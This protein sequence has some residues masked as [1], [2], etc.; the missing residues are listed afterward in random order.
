MRGKLTLLLLTAAACSYD[1]DPLDPRLGE[2]ASGGDATG[3]VADGGTDGGAAGAAGEGG[4]A[5]STGEGGRAGTAGGAGAAGAAGAAAGNAGQAGTA[6]SAGQPAGGEGGGVV[7]AGAGGAPTGGVGGWAGAPGGEAG[8]AGTAGAAAA[9]GSCTDCGTE[10][11]DLNTSTDH[12]GACDRPCNTLRVETL[13]CTDGVCDSTCE[14]GTANCSRP[15]APAADNGCETSVSTSVINCG[16]CGR[17][18]DSTNIDTIRCR[19]GLCDGTCVAGWA[20]CNQP[21]APELDDGCETRTAAHPDCSGCA[22]YEVCRDGVCS[23]ACDATGLNAL[24]VVGADSPLSAADQVAYDWLLSELGFGVTVVLDVDAPTA[25]VDA[26]ALVVIS[27]T[28]FGDTPLGNAF[29]G[30]N[31]PVVTWERMLF[32]EFGLTGP[33]LDTHYGLEAGQTELTLVDP[34]HPAA[35]GLEGTVTVFT[36]AADATW[37]VPAVSA[38]TIATSVNDSSHA[39]LFAIETGDGLYDGTPAPAR[40]MGLFLYDTGPS[41]ATDDAARLVLASFCWAAGL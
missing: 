23:A 38:T 36:A 4:V 15:A 37:G 41:I 19:G 30:G 34:C 12:C 39:S 7:V 10:C 28:A 14:A 3:G 18:C 13:S 29:S 1:W 22:Q 11:V 8:T 31:V 9:G 33:T 27:S 25:S 2:R 32:D 26:I 6:G 21:A 24:F 17:V 20:N 5:G 35:A 40:R 16:E